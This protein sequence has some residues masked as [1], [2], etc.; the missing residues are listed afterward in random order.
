MIHA[1]VKIQNSVK[2]QPSCT[3]VTAAFWYQVGVDLVRSLQT[4][5]EGN[6][7]LLTA[8]CYF[9][10]WAKAV[11]IQDK[12]VATIVNVLFKLLRQKGVASVYLHDQGT[13]FVNE[14][15]KMLCSMMGI[16]KRITTAYHLQTNGMDERWNLTLQTA[17]RKFNPDE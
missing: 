12:T 14:I 8:S 6:K 3:P 5:K 4:T 17:L 11:P 10:Q 7:Y 15:N 2:Y 9:T 16:S 1:N 13:E